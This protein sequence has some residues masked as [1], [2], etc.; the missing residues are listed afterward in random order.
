MMSV[1]HSRV[2]ILFDSK[3]SRS[4]DIWLLVW[5]KLGTLRHFSQLGQSSCSM[6]RNGLCVSQQMTRA[7]WCY[8]ISCDV[9][10][11]KKVYWGIRLICRRYINPP[12]EVFLRPTDF[13]T[14]KMWSLSSAFALSFLSVAY[15]SIGPSAN[16]YIENDVVSPDG[17]SRSYVNPSTCFD[18]NISLMT[19]V[20]LCWQVPCRAQR[21]SLDLSL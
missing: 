17:F 12:L 18:L 19:I 15:G 7:G 2:T 20:E 3:A 4:A 8:R 13:V 16:L 21:R 1:I 10:L 14:F 5:V 11:S 9:S 6:V